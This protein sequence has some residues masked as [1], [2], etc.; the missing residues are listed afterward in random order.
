MLPPLPAIPL[1]SSASRILRQS[2]IL[3]CNNEVKKKKERKKRTKLKNNKT[4]VQFI[5]FIFVFLFITILTHEDPVV[6]SKDYIESYGEWF[7]FDVHARHYYKVASVQQFWNSE[8]KKIRNRKIEIIIRWLPRLSPRYTFHSS[9]NLIDQVAGMW[10][11][12]SLCTR[13]YRSQA[14]LT[15]VKWMCVWRATEMGERQKNAATKLKQ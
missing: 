9:A 10:W 7:A 2:G 8:K 14:L 4:S 15:K 1:E 3:Q 6:A 12:L 13:Q 5:Y 11:W